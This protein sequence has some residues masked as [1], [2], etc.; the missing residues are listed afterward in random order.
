MKEK[1]KLGGLFAQGPLDWAGKGTSEDGA[2]GDYV[3]RSQKG[4]RG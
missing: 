1:V 4:V 3:D 2:G